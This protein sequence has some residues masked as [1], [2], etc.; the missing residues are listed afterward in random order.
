VRLEYG[1]AL[2]LLIVVFVPAFA[3][4][5]S[6]PAYIQFSEC[7]EFECPECPPCPTCP[8]C[9]RLAGYIVDMPMGFMYWWDEDGYIFGDVLYGIDLH[10]IPGYK[11]ILLVRIPRERIDYA[12]W[13]N[14]ETLDRGLVRFYAYN[15]THSYAETRRISGEFYIV[16]WYTI[17]EYSWYHI[18]LRLHIFIVREDVTIHDILR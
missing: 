16:G 4:I 8:E 9:P 15:A 5:Y 10:E 18:V 2:F 7:P 12:E 17:N 3:F 11:Y 14:W 13:T 1:L 6:P